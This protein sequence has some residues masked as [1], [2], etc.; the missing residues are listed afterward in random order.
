MRILN[1]EQVRQAFPMDR[2]IALMRETMAAHGR[3]EVFQP[4]R[5]TIEPP[6]LEG[7]VMLKPGLVAGPT[8]G[9]GMKALTIY[10]KNK[11]RGLE[12]IQAFVALLD[13]ETGV[14]L[15]I[16]EGGTVTEIRTAAVSAVATDLLAIP[17][18]GDLA[19][20]GAGAQARGHLL[21]MNVVRPLRRI[22]VWNHTPHRAEEFARW[23]AAAGFVVE[24]CDDVRR[25][26]QGADIV[27]TVT[28][29]MEP[30][31]HGDWVDDGTHVN[32]VGAYRADMRELHASVVARASVFAVDSRQ[33][34]FA[35]AGDLLLAIRDGVVPD[36]FDP[37]ELGE[38][39]VGSR[40]GRRDESAVT[41][42]ESLGLAIQDV[43]AAAAIHGYAAQNC[44]GTDVAFP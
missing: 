2:A 3:G 29:A 35:D 5:L 19:I 4:P 40:P 39:L 10:P 26:V 15:A 6:G 8:G 44:L 21:A 12:T 37:P 23:S 20:L 32:A 16:V 14:P 1:A 17:D 25:T 28:A 41:V 24:I 13:P 7:S 18:A 43:A 30:L 42:Y 9:F 11:T 36:D 22:R 27:C 31:L 33:G 34:A 38:L